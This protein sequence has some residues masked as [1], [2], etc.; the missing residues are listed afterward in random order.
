M[1]K[2]ISKNAPHSKA[3][4]PVHVI[5]PIWKEKNLIKGLNNVR[6]TPKFIK[7]DLERIHFRLQINVSFSKSV[8]AGFTHTG[9]ISENPSDFLMRQISMKT[10]VQVFAR[11]RL[12]VT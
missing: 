2:N 4:K 5:A 9:G 11:K 12:L 1:N 7:A 10:N 8:H 3:Q 6:F